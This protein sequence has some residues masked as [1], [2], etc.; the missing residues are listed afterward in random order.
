MTA[1]ATIENLVLRYFQ[2][3]QEPADLEEFRACLADNVVF[4]SPFGK[5]DGADA[6]TEMV[7]NTE[8]PWEG[9][10]LLTSTFDAN[11]GALFYDGIDSKTGARMRVG[12]H[13]RVHGGQ[14]DY[15]TAAICRLD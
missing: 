13:L 8:A 5:V 2:S 9:V 3:W 15:I 14:I 4:D 10:T 7:R 6:L 12:E 11:S 1:E